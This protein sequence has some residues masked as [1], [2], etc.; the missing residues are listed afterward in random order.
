MGEDFEELPRAFFDSTDAILGELPEAIDNGDLATQQRLVHSLKSS[1]ANMGGTR[2]S[3]LAKSL[4][5]QCK[6]GQALSEN[7]LERLQQEAGELISAL[8]VFIAA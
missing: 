8:Q 3:A 4:E 7:D 1:S 6:D 2:L 5:Q